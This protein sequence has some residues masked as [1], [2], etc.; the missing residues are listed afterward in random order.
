MT[1][2]MKPTT[3]QQEQV[4]LSS[5]D[6]SSSVDACGITSVSRPRISRATVVSFIVLLLS[7]LFWRLSQ[8]PDP[9]VT[10]V[11]AALAGV[12]G[13]SHSPHSHSTP[14]NSTPSH[15]TTTGPS[16]PESSVPHRAH[17][18]AAAIQNPTGIDGDPNEFVLGTWILDDGIRRVIENR[19]DGTATM[20]VTFSYLTSFRYGEKLRLNLKWT[21]KDDVL[22]HEIV[23]GFPES[24]MKTLI[25][26]F[27]DKSYFKIVRLDHQ[28]MHL[29]DF[30]DPPDEYLWLRP[31]SDDEQT[32]AAAKTPGP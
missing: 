30:D 16:Q 20:D 19:P 2:E 18:D 28:Q 29:V 25:H 31:A 8:T 14:S 27:G 11:N 26:D 1:S 24:G 4:S 12:A 21:L 10:P 23:D 22:T 32:S 15:S 7:S 5:S 17:A 6:V 9:A 3:P 13:T